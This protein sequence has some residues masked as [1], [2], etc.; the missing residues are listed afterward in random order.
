MS[1][2]NDLV[3]KSTRRKIIHERSLKRQKTKSLIIGTGIG[4]VLGVAAGLLL[5]P[6]SGAQTRKQLGENFTGAVQRIRQ[7]ARE[8]LQEEEDTGKKTA[9]TQSKAK[10]KK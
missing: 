1:V 2:L 3:Q 9:G 8:K 5:A 6:S 4:T 10:S 7:G